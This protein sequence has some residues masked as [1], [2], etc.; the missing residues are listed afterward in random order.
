[1]GAAGSQR[2]RAGAAESGAARPND[3]AAGGYPGAAAPQ[4]AAG[5]HYV[6]PNMYGGQRAM[7][8]SSGIHGM[9]PYMDGSRPPELR[10]ENLYPWRPMPRQ[11]CSATPGWVSPLTPC[12]SLERALMPAF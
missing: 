9:F 8:Q 6:H 2:R 5:P 3:G 4:P 1:M 12:A 7:P 10:G 11:V